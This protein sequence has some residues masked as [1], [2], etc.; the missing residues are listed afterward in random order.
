MYIY[1]YNMYFVKKINLDSE[2]QYKSS[3]IVEHVNKSISSALSA[4]E[5]V[6]RT[7]VK[8][9]CGREAGEQVKIIEIHDFNQVNEPTVDSMLLY[10]LI[11][12]K[13]RIFVYQKKTTISKV[14]AWTWGTNDVV[15]SQFGRICIFE[16]EEYN[17]LSV[18][19]FQNQIFFTPNEEMVA[20]GPA[21][22]RIP[23]PMTMAPMCDLIDELKKSPKFKARFECMSDSE[24][25]Y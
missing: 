5:N 11:D 10:R 3:E 21:K 15:T 20:V 7:F 4:L 1:R 19:S 16:L 17:K 22:I 23:K 12:D 25:S 9:E 14:S 24:I 2:K 18:P 8:E 6:A 13:H